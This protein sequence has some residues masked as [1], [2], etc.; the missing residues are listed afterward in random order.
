M[1]DIQTIKNYYSTASTIE[2]IELAKKPTELREEIIPFLKAELEKRNEVE[3]VRKINKLL[4]NIDAEKSVVDLTFWNKEDI[5]LEIKQRLD[6]G[7]MVE[8]IRID[9]LDRGIDITRLYTSHKQLNESITE[10]ITKLRM[11]DVDYLEIKDILVTEK[12]LTES[13]AGISIIE[14]QEQGKRNHQKGI[15]FMTIGIALLVAS[16]LILLNGYGERVIIPYGAI[17]GGGSLIA[18]GAKQKQ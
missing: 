18:L 15:I 17:L 16:A 3:E 2:L 12:G 9:L 11:K 5:L 10:F 4:D 13:D 7:E 6:A 8:T 1:L 14:T